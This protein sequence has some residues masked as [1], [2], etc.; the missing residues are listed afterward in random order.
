MLLEK[1]QTY[2]GTTTMISDCVKRAEEYSK[3]VAF[4]AGVG[5]G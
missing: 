4:G 1:L 5:G 2:D 3:I